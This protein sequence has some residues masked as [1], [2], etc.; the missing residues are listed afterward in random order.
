MPGLTLRRN[1][2]RQDGDSRK[3]THCWRSQ[4]GATHNEGL[5]T[6]DCSA[7]GFRL[8]LSDLFCGVLICALEFSEGNIDFVPF[9]SFVGRFVRRHLI[10]RHM[11]WRWLALLSLFS[12]GTW[13]AV[14]W[15]FHSQATL[16]IAVTKLPYHIFVHH[17]LFIRY[18]NHCRL[19]YA[20]VDSTHLTAAL[21]ASSIRHGLL[22]RRFFKGFVD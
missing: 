19:L 13:F 21:C 5:L 22:S 1:R 20:L 16:Q 8:V 17:S 9:S 10:R 18:Q 2:R 12:L 15:L 3:V 7:V 4:Q 14:T 11:T 6:R